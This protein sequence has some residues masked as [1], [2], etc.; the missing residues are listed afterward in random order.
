MTRRRPTI[1]LVL[2]VLT[3]LASGCGS[4]SASDGAGTTTAAPT[5]TTS[6]DTTSPGDATTAPVATDAPLEILVSNDDGY[7]AEG[8]D[9]LTEALRQIEGVEVTVVAPLDQ[10]SGSGGK[11][12]EGDLTATDVELASGFEAKAVDGFPADAIRAAFDDLGAK[13]DLVVTGINEGQNLG[14]VV[15]FSGTVGAARVA[16]ARGVPALATSQGSGE[17][18]DYESAIPVIVEWI[19]DHRADLAAGDAPVEVTNINVPSCSTGDPRGPVEVEADADAEVGDALK[20][21]DCASDASIDP[22]DG[23]VA[24]FN[25]GYITISTLPDEP[26]A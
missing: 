5:E 24:A 12:T 6:P 13:P 16:V 4:D 8:I 21:Q 20:E 7:S 9:V 26:A 2:A 3:L 19:E 10:R 22:A 17:T 23:D 11:T 25:L 15:D 18:V 14:P 1:V